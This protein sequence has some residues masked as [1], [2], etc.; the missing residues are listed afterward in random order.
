MCVQSEHGILTFT[1]SDIMISLMAYGICILIFG[2][3]AE[4]AMLIDD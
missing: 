3:V 2:G 1:V 4:S